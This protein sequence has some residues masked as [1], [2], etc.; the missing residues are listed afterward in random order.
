MFLET[1]A[2]NSHHH[3]KTL[4]LKI[5]PGSIM[6]LNNCCH[7]SHLTHL[8]FCFPL[9]S[10]INTSLLVLDFLKMNIFSQK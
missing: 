5:D 8:S 10:I 6:L 2:I 4:E 1:D 9:V 7:H 3:E